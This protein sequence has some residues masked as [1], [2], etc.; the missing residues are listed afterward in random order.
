MHGSERQVFGGLPGLVVTPQAF[1]LE[2]RVKSAVETAADEERTDLGPSLVQ[3]PPLHAYPSQCERIGS[4][5]RCA[6][7]ICGRSAR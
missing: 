1:V 6:P 3:N 4:V 7:E 5:H 2:Y